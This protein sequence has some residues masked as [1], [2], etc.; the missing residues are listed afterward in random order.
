MSYSLLSDGGGR[1]SI[2]PTSGVV[3][4]TETLD[5]E[6]EAGYEIRVLAS[7]TDGTTSEASFQITI[8]DVNEFALSPIS[9][10]DPMLNRVVETAGIGTLA[11][12]QA[13]AVDKDAT[14]NGVAY[15]LLES[16]NGLFTIDSSTG[17]VSVGAAPSANPAAASNVHEKFV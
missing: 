2:D 9:D 14:T 13:S 10:S 4:T 8:V 16:S 5:A 3:C 6:V 7:S 17:I 12:I 15:E 11:G 1:F